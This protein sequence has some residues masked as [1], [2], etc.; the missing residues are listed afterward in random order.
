MKR[1]QRYIPGLGAAK[2]G[3]LRK[4]LRDRRRE[5]AERFVMHA[6]LSI[7]LDHAR[8]AKK[9]HWVGRYV[10]QCARRA[11][12]SAALAETYRVAAS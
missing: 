10:V 1:K 9:D 4:V 6:Q 11:Y 5:A 12:L 8:G 2:S 7:R 3:H